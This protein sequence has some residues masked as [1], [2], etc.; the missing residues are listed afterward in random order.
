M[1]DAPG[2]IL[3]TGAN[4]GIGAALFKA[5]AEAGWRTIAWVR[6]GRTAPLEALSE[7]AR[8]RAHVQE[9]NFTTTAGLAAA[10]AAVAEPIDVL[11]NNAATFA[12]AAFRA[13]DFDPDV[14]QDAFWTN[15]SVP[16]LIARFLH[17]RLLEGRRKLIIVM[18]T[19]NASI[20]GNR[21]GEMLAYRASKSAL[22]QIARTMA[23]EWAGE[24]ITTVMLNPG[25]VRTDMG[26]PNA[27]LAPAEAAAA[28][29]RFVTEA[30]TTLNGRF[31]NPDRSELPW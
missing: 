20:G 9:V 26:G 3:L 8:G 31:V 1:S 18:S 11:F 21:N 23:W 22:N 29:L 4:R 16:A 15:A 30:D 13:L 2:S 10:A 17:P 19:G 25:W 5:F 27:P 24:G 12:N 7:R 6:P 28:I 14:L